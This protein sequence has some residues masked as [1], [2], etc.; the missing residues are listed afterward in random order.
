M[1]LMNKAVLSAVLVSLLASTIV[2]QASAE[3]RSSSFQVIGAFSLQKLD[4]G[5]Y[6]VTDGIG[7]TLTLVP[8]GQKPPPDTNQEDIIRTPVRRVAVVSGQDASI[9][10]ALG[11]IETVVAV[12]GEPAEWVSIPYIENGL[13][14]GSVL[15]AGKNMVLNYELFIQSRP[16]LILTWDEAM[17]PFFSELGIPVLITNTER[18]RD[19]ETQMKFSK[20]LGPIFGKTREAD[21]FVN[22]VLTT[23]SRVQSITQKA[24]HKPK[25]IW[26]DLFPKRILAE[27]G[28]SFHAEIARVGGG[29]YLFDDIYGA[30]CL[31]ISLERFFRSASEADVLI[32]YRTPFVGMDNKAKI[33][34][35]FPDLASTKPL[36][37]GKIIVPMRHYERSMHRLDDIIEEVAAYLH[38]DLF[39][40]VKHKYLRLLPD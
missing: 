12:T 21:D 26:V 2:I 20:F 4:Q 14:N 33:A 3:T 9:I 31:E 17:I 6:R 22:R 1:K 24:K 27:P 23:V 29:Q 15:A 40:E 11:A 35:N 25:V 7:R 10:Y 32:T 37:T 16:E 36:T 34:K 18:A 8:R 39:P 5:C 19:L 28:N 30:S 13:K 38:P